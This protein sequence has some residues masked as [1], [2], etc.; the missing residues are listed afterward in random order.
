MA[1]VLCQSSTVVGELLCLI[2]AGRW[3]SILL[4]HFF[5]YHQR[6]IFKF[7]LNQV[8]VKGVLGVYIGVGQS[9]EGLA[10]AVGCTA[11]EYCLNLSCGRFGIRFHCSVCFHFQEIIKGDAMRP[12]LRSRQS[13]DPQRISKNYKSSCTRRDRRNTL[14]QRIET[15]HA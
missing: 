14:S 2:G 7:A 4:R 8:P 9:P 15:R 3:T 13:S 12:S 11:I 1:V 6:Y 5:A 10:A